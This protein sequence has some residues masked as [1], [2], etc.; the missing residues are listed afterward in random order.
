MR[1]HLPA[2]LLASALAACATGKSDESDLTFPQHVTIVPGATKTV[3]E[4]SAV[5]AHGVVTG[6]ASLPMRTGDLVVHV[7]PIPDG[8]DLL[9]IDELRLLYEDVVLPTEF[10]HQGQTLTGIVASLAE[11]LAMRA[12]HTDD[13]VVWGAATTDVKLAWNLRIDGDD[14][15]LLSQTLPGLQLELVM[16]DDEGAH[17]AD[18]E[19]IRPGVMWSWADVLG[20]GELD[21][22]A[23]ATSGAID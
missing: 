19:V 6:D 15:R 20:F 12:V 8:G 18:L 9:V 3:V 2:I 17:R 21:L 22:H 13:G 10:F 14:H 11:P 5:G 16:S 23:T 4:A 7:E 1:L